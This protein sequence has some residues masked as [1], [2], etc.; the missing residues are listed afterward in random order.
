MCEVKLHFKICIKN[1]V[2]RKISGNCYLE[3]SYLY[4]SKIHFFNVSRNKHL[5]RIYNSHYF[6]NFSL[7]KIKVNLFKRRKNI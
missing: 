6:F 7:V 2:F 4:P 1:L 5:D 3:S